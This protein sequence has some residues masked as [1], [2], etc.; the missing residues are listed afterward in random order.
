M[1]LGAGRFKLVRIAIL[2]RPEEPRPLVPVIE[3]AQIM[4]GAVQ[5]YTPSLNTLPHDTFLLIADM[6]GGPLDQAAGGD[7]FDSGDGVVASD[8]R[9]LL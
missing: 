6:G 7:G 5:F 3:A 4:R 1:N 8:Q 2:E 9:C